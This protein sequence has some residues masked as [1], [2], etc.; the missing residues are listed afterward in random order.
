MYLNLIPFYDWI[1]FHCTYLPY[2]AYPSFTKHE[3]FHLLAVV[4]N[5]PIITDVQIY[6]FKFLFFFLLYKY[7]QVELLD[8]MLILYLIFWGIAIL[9]YIAATPLYIPSRSTQV[10]ISSH[11]CQ[12]FLFI[13]IATL[14]DM[15]W[16]YILILMCISLM[17]SNVEHLF[18]SYWLSV[19][20]LDTYLIFK[21]F[22]QFWIGLSLVPV[23]AF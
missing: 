9:F 16:Y 14:I 3:S 13:V 22:A 23:V 12:H 5:A 6:L 8:Q 4:N 11:P 2:F 20:S 7:P 15:K 21:S 10:S 1:I 17:T 19:C 18:M